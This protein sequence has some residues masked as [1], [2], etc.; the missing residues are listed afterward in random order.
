[1]G[2]MDTVLYKSFDKISIGLFVNSG[3]DD[4]TKETPWS[5]SANYTDQVTAAC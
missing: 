2:V 1:M 5:K 3:T 4:K